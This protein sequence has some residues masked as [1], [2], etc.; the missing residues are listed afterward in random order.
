MGKEARW[1]KTTPCGAR[2]WRG[3]ENHAD[4]A[5]AHELEKKTAAGFAGRGQA[6]WALQDWALVNTQNEL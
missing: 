4:W 5:V 6:I 2:A 1:W 3:Q